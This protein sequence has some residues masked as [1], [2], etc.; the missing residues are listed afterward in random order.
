MNKEAIEQKIKALDMKQYAI[1][2]IINSLYGAFGN[3]FF[4]F[5]NNDIAQSITVQGQDLIKF[6]IRAINYFFITKWH[7]DK[8]LHEKLGISHLKVN[9]IIKEACIY[10]DTDSVYIN[11]SLA[12]NSVEGLKLS[13]EENM[14]FC[15][16][17]IDYVLTDFLDSAFKKYAMHFNTK[18]K[19]EFKLENISSSGIWVA[20]KNYA[21]RVQFEDFFLD[22]PELL[23]KGIDY[24]KPSFPVYARKK[25]GEILNI[26]LDKGYDIQIEYDIISKIKEYKKSF[27]LNEIEDISFNYNV[28]VYNKYVDSTNPLKLKKGIPIR[29]RASAYHNHFIDNTKNL[30][31]AKIRQGNKVKFYYAKHD[32]NKEMNVF[33]FMPGNYPVEFAIPMDVDEQFFRLMVEPINKLLNAMNMHKI[34]IHLRREIKINMP[35]IKKKLTDADIYPLY[36]IDNK[37]LEYT[38]MPTKFNKYLMD[39]AKEIPDHILDDYIKI[40]TTYGLNSEVVANI[41]RDKYIKRKQTE[42]KKKKHKGLMSQLP[43][44]EFELFEQ[45]CVELKAQKYKVGID[46]ETYEPTFMRT[47]TEKVYTLGIQN[48]LKLKSVEQYVGIMNLVFKDELANETEIELA[49]IERAAKK[50]AAKEA[51]KEA[52]AEKVNEINKN[53]EDIVEMAQNAGVAENDPS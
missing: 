49:K 18:N 11:F 9:P 15:K 47:K 4:Y 45:A 41:E 40:I 10:S 12:I 22:K 34:N 48:L 31:Y 3:K 52:A 20:K 38:E 7:L 28:S 27:S 37:K 53:V 29:A 6:S 25:I 32:K 5:H 50:D 23:A 8:K 42:F 35:R 13:A 36:I 19:M 2:I 33:S 1:K 14:H 24:A 26:M 51:L 30:K 43:S 17:I 44:Y 21:L 16:N 39:Q 46:D